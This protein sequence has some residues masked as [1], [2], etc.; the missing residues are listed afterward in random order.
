MNYSKIKLLST[1]LSILF[2]TFTIT[3]AKMAS[4]E[5]IEIALY[6]DF[7]SK[8]ESHIS[9]IEKTIEKKQGLLNKTKKSDATQYTSLYDD[10]AELMLSKNEL[11]KKMERYDDI[12]NDKICD[13]AWKYEEVEF[14]KTQ[15]Y[16]TP[17]HDKVA[18]TLQNIAA[19]YEE[20]H[21]PMAEKFLQSILDI[22]ENIHTRQSAEVANAH[23]GLGDY[24]RFSMANF[25][26]A[27]KHYGLAK[28][29]REELYKSNDP[30]ITENASKLAMSIYYH[31]DKTSEAEK[32]LLHSVKLRENAD[33]DSHF[34]L[35]DAYVDMGMYYS[36]K[37]KYA[38]AV[39]YL[40]K[41]LSVSGDRR[42][43][44]YINLLS[45]IS[46]MYMNQKDF[47]NALK[48]AEE[49]Y[50]KTKALYKDS[51]DPR[52]LEMLRNVEEIREIK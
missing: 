21:R 45:E 40:K 11:L 15:Y 51:Q 16:K 48:Y 19:L 39:I 20:C 25:K 27:I 9:Q 18:K 5:P 13:F 33:T 7:N 10:I 50:E 12:D 3:Y 37:Q 17:F 44:E 6:T 46:T 26:D 38:D 36:M 29:I 14:I 8:E 31:G 4:K 43:N 2:L 28:S 32:L 34:S 42:G 35:Y 49:A 41:A 23:D 24:Y 1:L 22:K 30:K 52:V 47:K